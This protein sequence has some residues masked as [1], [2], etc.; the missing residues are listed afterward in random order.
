[1]GVEKLAFS[2]NGLKSGDRKCP[3]GPRK[4]FA[5]HPGAMNFPQVLRGSVFQHPQDNALS[6]ISDCHVYRKEHDVPLMLLS[7]SITGILFTSHE[8]DQIGANCHK[9]STRVSND[10]QPPFDFQPDKVFPRLIERFT[11]DE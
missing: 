10:A 4:S 3:S 7:D 2:T 8:A 6:R 11:C 9:L 5:G 1:V